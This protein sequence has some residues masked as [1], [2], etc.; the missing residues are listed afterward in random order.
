[1]ILVITISK[2]FCQHYCFYSPSQH[3]NQSYGCSLSVGI[4]ISYSVLLSSEYHLANHGLF[5][6]V[7]DFPKKHQIPV[8]TKVRLGT[9]E[10]D[11]TNQTIISSA[12]LFE[13]VLFSAPTQQTP[14]S[15]PVAFHKLHLWWWWCTAA[16][17]PTAHLAV[18][19]F[20]WNDNPEVSSGK[21]EG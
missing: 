8:Y 16:M 7:S 1:M 9:A 15:A 18:A 2:E 17:Q 21:V 12:T 5:L 11:R 6:T 13:V 14:N 3:V 20:R 19:H 10:R 4:I